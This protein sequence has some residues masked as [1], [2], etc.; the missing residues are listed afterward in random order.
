MDVRV[1]LW[2]KLNTEELMLLNCVLEKTLESSLDGKEI[3][4]VHPK[5]N[6]YWVFIGKT[7]VEAETPIIWLPDEKNWLIWKYSDAKKDWGQEEKGTT[8]DEMVGWYHRLN[9]HEFG[10]T[11]GVGDGQWSLA[12]CGSWGHKNSDMTEWL[13]LTIVPCLVLTAVSWPAYRFLRKQVSWSG[14]P[15][16]LR[17][18]HSLLWSTKWKALA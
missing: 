17:I 12:C 18:F 2:R 13:K 16:S 8:E 4:P 11:P 3:P 10:W 6:Q 14:I 1:R 7:D 5:G 9:W 15:I